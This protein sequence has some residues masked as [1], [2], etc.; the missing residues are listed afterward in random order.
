MAAASLEEGGRNVA[1]SW[2]ALFSG[3]V[4]SALFGLQAMGQMPGIA[5]P[6]IKA[7]FVGGTLSCSQPEKL[8]IPES[9]AQRAM[10][11]ARLATILR[12]SLYDDAKGIVNAAREKEI[13]NLASK[14]AG[15]LKREKVPKMPDY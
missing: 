15:K 6:D 10:L 5:Q 2:F 4:A 14:L 7:S 9:L 12:D 8:P 3:P 1:R 13:K 11:K